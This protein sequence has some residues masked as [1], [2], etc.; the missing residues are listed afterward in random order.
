MGT[1]ICFALLLAMVVTTMFIWRKYWNFNI[2]PL[3]YRA[4][5]SQSDLQHIATMIIELIQTM[6]M[7]PSVKSLNYTL[8]TVGMMFQ[9]DLSSVIDMK[10]GTFWILINIL[11]AIAPIYF[12]LL[13]VI[14]LNLKS[15]FPNSYVISVATSFAMVLLPIFGNVV[16]MPFIAILLSVFICYETS[17]EDIGDAFLAKD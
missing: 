8:W 6:S 1:V 5:F 7:G 9:I 14:Q 13:L 4:P 17:G 16:F 2:I 11:L 10:E 15:R 12:L 3:N